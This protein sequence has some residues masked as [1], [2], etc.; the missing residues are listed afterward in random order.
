MQNTLLIR[1]YSFTA[2][3]AA[4]LLLV[5]C[6]K[7]SSSSGS[8]SSDGTA[9]TT[10]SCTMK[11]PGKTYDTCFMTR[12]SITGYDAKLVCET[13]AV[14]TYSTSACNPDLFART[15]EVT[16]TIKSKGQTSDETTLNFYTAASTTKCYPPGVEKIINVVSAN[17]STPA[18]SSNPTASST[19]VP[20]SA[21]VTLVGS[22]TVAP[23]FYCYQ[24]YTPYY[25]AADE[26]TACIVNSGHTW[27]DTGCLPDM[28][29]AKSPGQCK[30]VDL[31]NNNQPVKISIMYGW[32]PVDAKNFC[33]PRMLTGQ[34]VIWVPN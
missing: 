32:N 29:G 4:T 22:C 18:S 11:E 12:N 8:N 17:S 28:A 1:R 10:G 34:E 30:T 6:G 9:Y 31:R 13:V 3:L 24:V 16:G 27:S 7:S 26:K 5:S 25:K 15:C 2:M 21:P 20:S 23:T 33:S 14:G 19:P